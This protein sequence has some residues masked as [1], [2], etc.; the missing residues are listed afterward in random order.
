M[1][2]QERTLGAGEGR[3]K[4]CSAFI[5]VLFFYF[6]I[7]LI[8]FALKIPH[9]VPPDE[10][11]HF[12]YCRVFAQTW[13]FPVN[14]EQ[15]YN[16]GNLTHIPW[17]YYYL[18][19]KF[20]SLNLLPI[21]DLV[22][23]RFLNILLACLTT[24]FSFRWIS[25]LTEN[26]QTRLFFLVLVTNTPMLTFLGASVNYD[27]LVNLCAVLALY[28]THL[29]FL[30][31]RPAYFFGAGIAMLA[32][33]LTKVAFLPLVPIFLGILLVHEKERLRGL[34]GWL[35]GVREHL[36][37]PEKGLGLLFLVLLVMCFN[38]YGTNLLQFKKLIPAAS[39]VMSEE[40]FMQHRISARDHVISMYRSGEWDYQKAVSEAG[41]IQH[42][43]DQR[44]ALYILKL[45][46]ANKEKEL[47][48][49][50]RLAYSYNWL[51]N[52]LANSVGICAHRPMVKTVNELAI[53]QLIFLFSFFVTVRY[54]KYEEAGFMINHS[55]VIVSCYA[56]YLMLFHNYQIYLWSLNPTLGIQ[57]RYIF[58]VLVPL[59][60]IMAYYL[61]NYLRIWLSSLV[62]VVVSVFFI[63][64][65]FPYFQLHA[66]TWLNRS[67]DAVYRYQ[68]GDSYRKA[69]DIQNALFEYQEAV[70][71]DPNNAWY[72]RFLGDLYSETGQSEKALAQYLTAIRV[73]PQTAGF[74]FLAG[75]AYQKIGISDKAVENYQNAIR[76][77]PENVWYYRFLGDL[78]RDS[79][80]LTKAS[81]Q[82]REA[83]RIEP[84]NEYC[85]EQLKRVVE[86][87]KE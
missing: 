31:R 63:W 12:G 73:Q 25:L 17:L 84:D 18:M 81:Q 52:L 32:G 42:H 53:Y 8:Y 38:L 39:Q 30:T 29:F 57:G 77:D 35:R 7:R 27:N 11:T 78:Y 79:N 10:V 71:L 61:T 58:P 80:M 54:W 43:G 13:G 45:Q 46:A 36:S 85:Q 9:Y 87:T 66:T 41:K 37:M 4:L 86:K 55:M 60:A 14:S 67:E 19:G 21:S 34:A 56:L 74:Y 65:D 62:I 23:L 26:K 59:L 49:M 24:F 40:Q 82:Y 2:K 72:H 16:L 70:R 69:G 47:P 75:K 33:S 76:L 68:Q 22:Y 83:L 5:A 1:Q 28:Y 44:T 48:V 50:S 20:L 3:D 51:E 64:G 6:V 15:T